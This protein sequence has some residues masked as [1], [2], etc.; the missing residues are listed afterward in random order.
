LINNNF[1]YIDSHNSRRSHNSS[2]SHNSHIIRILVNIHSSFAHRNI[3][4]VPKVRSPSPSSLFPVQNVK[5]IFGEKHY[6]SDSPRGDIVDFLL[7]RLG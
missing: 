6:C 3:L 2:S 1:G 5:R 4:V 7:G